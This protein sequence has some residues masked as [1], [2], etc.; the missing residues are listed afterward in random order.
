MDFLSSV[1]NSAI[2]II[3]AVIIGSTVHE[4]FHAWTAWKLGDPTAKWNGRLT[5]NPLAH[6]DPFGLVAMIIA[7]IGWSK[8]VPIDE[9]NFKNRV[10]G[11]AIVSI[12]GPLSNLSLA[13]IAAVIFRFIPSDWTFMLSF[14]MSFLFVNV[15][16]F[17]F[18]LLPIP[19]LDGFRIVRVL[20]PESIRRYWESLE[21]YFPF[22]LILLITP[23]SPFSGAIINL[24]SSVVVGIVQFLLTF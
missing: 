12:A 1:L 10:Q 16:L 13:V 20:L 24:V 9:N 21:G 5:L 7:K 18:N 17:V 2:Y 4:F 6:I 19:P 15:S 8:P 22:I 23:F 14:L 11:T 3:P